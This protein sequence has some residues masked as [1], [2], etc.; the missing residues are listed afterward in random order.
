[1]NRILRIER[2]TGLKK[3]IPRIDPHPCRSALKRSST[4]MAC[5]SQA[6]A[7]AAPDLEDVVENRKKQG[8][9]AAKSTDIRA[10]VIELATILEKRLEDNGGTLDGKDYQKGTSVLMKTYGIIG[11]SKA[12]HIYRQLCEEDVLVYSHQINNLF[13]KKLSR[14][15][16]GG[17]N[18]SIF[19]P[20][21]HTAP[22]WNVQVTRAGASFQ[23]EVLESKS[24]YNLKSYAGYSKLGDKD[25]IF[26]DSG[27]LV[28]SCLKETTMTL[29]PA[30][31]KADHMPTLSFIPRIFVSSNPRTAP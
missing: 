18:L 2:L 8:N 4:A 24:V 10:Y 26:V 7:N 6:P 1:M 12:V 22:I 15:A 21:G 16:F 9:K 23:V 3:I 17:V 14:S 30:Q 19:I 28:V 29:E 31:T 5:A 27:R 11:K 20:P 25:G 13:V